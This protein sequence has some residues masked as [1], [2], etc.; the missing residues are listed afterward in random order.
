MT[1]ATGP[2]TVRAARGA[3]PSCQRLAAGGGAALPA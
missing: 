1:D 2:V 3:E